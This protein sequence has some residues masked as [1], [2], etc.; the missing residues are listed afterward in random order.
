MFN[1]FKSKKNKNEEAQITPE[2]VF[3]VQKNGAF[4][5]AGKTKSTKLTNRKGEIV[6]ENDFE[7]AESAEFE[8]GRKIEKKEVLKK[9]RV[10]KA[11]V[12][13]YKDLEG[14]TIKKLNIGL[15]LV[16]HRIFII[17]LFYGFLAS[18]GI[19]TWGYFLFSFGGYLIVGMRN[20]DKDIAQIVTGASIDH[21]IVV[22]QSPKNLKFGNV[23]VIKSSGDKYDFLMEITNINEQHWGKFEYYFTASGKNIGHASGFILPKE[24]KYFYLLGEELKQE[25]SGVEFKIDDVKWSRISSADYPDWNKFYADHTR[26]EISDA[27]FVSE[28][29]SELTEKVDLN[30]LRFKVKNNTAYSYWEVTL[31]VRLMNR[32][33]II[34][35]EK[36]VLN[37]LTA[38][39]TRDIEMTWPG[40]LSKVSEILIVPEV[41][42]IDESVYIKPGG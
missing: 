22:R 7:V 27:E 20:D 31:G 30:L 15:W 39:E 24:T 28:S 3:G 19:V 26:I 40:K 14:I 12:E 32:N 9:E 18:I 42:I 1:L 16:E 34:G 21:E 11:D 17:N 13:R 37:S 38:G 35:A 2:D 6:G 4:E 29:L 10:R 41:N 25:P 23:K 36:I 8:L 33:T 5:E